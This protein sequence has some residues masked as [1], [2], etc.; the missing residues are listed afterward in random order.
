MCDARNERTWSSSRRR[1]PMSDPRFPNEP[2]GYREA[3]ESL[4]AE[5]AELR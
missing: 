3:R 2:A 5:E 1:N 4:L